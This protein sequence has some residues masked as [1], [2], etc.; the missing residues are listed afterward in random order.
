L[1][2]A[3]SY[4]KNGRINNILLSQTIAM[5]LNINITNLH[6]GGLILQAGT[7]ATANQLEDGPIPKNRVC[8]HYEGDIWIATVNEYTLQ[9]IQ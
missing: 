5:A 9:N 2:I 3:K 6:L 1:W 7:L 8:G 4:L